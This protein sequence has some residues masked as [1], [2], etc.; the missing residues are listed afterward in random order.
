MIPCITATCPSI[1]SCPLKQPKQH[2]M[3]YAMVYVMVHVRKTYTMP[4]TLCTSAFRRG[5]GIWVHVG[6]SFKKKGKK[7]APTLVHLFLI[8]GIPF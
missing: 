6:G 2:G 5:D 3:V 7:D 8:D 1:R 4:Q